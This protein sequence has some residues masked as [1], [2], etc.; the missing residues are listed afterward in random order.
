MVYFSYISLTMQEFILALA[1][2]DRSTDAVLA[3]CKV[4]YTSITYVKGDTFRP[5]KV[6]I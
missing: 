3:F 2:V 1:G 6:R 5:I 4:F